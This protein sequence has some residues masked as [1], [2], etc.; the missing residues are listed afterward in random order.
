M[1]FGQWSMNFKLDEKM[2]KKYK[3]QQIIYSVVNTTNLIEHIS[4][5]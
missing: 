1:L 2:A 5:S 3:F 4:D